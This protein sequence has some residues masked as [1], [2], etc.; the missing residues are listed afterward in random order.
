MNSPQKTNATAATAAIATT[1]ASGVAIPSDLLVVGYVAG[2]YGLQGWIRIRPYSADA[3]ALLHAKTWWLGDPD[4][5]AQLRDIDMMQAKQHSGDVVAQLVGVAGREA[6]EALRGTVVQ[7]SRKHFPS[8]SDDEF[9]W[10]D[11]IGLEV[12]NLQ[13]QSLGVVGDLMD[14]GAHPILR[15]VP[16]VPTQAPVT[17]ADSKAVAEILIPYV[18]QFVKSVVLAEKKITV[19][20]GLDY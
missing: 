18:D 7:I 13:G 16:A 8:L 12:E 19:D 1:T 3:D 17:D 2:A 5:P 15:I 20:W 11:L 6:A 14:N 4:V 10:V 9:Y